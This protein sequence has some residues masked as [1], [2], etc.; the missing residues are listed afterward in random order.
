VSPDPTY[1]LRWRGGASAALELFSPPGAK[2]HTYQ[3]K[4]TPAFR[5]TL[6]PPVVPR[7]ITQKNLDQINS[8]LED[9]VRSALGVRR[10][11]N[12]NGADDDRDTAAKLESLGQQIYMCIVPKHIRAELRAPGLFLE[13]GTDESLVG[14]PWELMYDGDDYLCNKHYIGRYV[15]VSDPPIPLLAEDA[16]HARG[17]L[18]KL[19]VLLIGVPQPQP[20]DGQQ[21]ER[22]QGAEAELQAL[23]ETLARIDGVELVVLKGRDANHEKVFAELQKEHHIVHYI[24]HAFYDADHPEESALVLHDTNMTT[25]FLSAFIDR[26]PMLCFINGCQSGTIDKWQ[27]QYG[28]YGLAQALLGTGTYMVGS[29][30]KLVDDVATKFATSFYDALLGQRKPLG[31]AVTSARCAT[32]DASPKGDFGWASY[33]YYGD[34]RVSFD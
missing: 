24:G 19:S 32:R 3:L 26:P 4:Y 34:P 22:L 6:R 23:V 12:G 14:Y 18:G 17:D 9:M 20:R 21:F 29:R 5:S 28:F 7:P 33:V 11:A 13:I 2:R 15:N 30:W 8:S 1:S 25:G 27:T 31:K 10:G 16:L